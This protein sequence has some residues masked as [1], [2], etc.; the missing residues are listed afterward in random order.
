MQTR[1]ASRAA[2][3]AA[4]PAVTAGPPA[5]SK[6][7][8]RPGQRAYLE[9]V[10]HGKKKIEKKQARPLSQRAKDYLHRLY[11]TATRPGSYQGPRKILATVRKEKK[12]KISWE[13]VKAWLAGEETYTIHRQRTGS[14]KRSRVIV[15]GIGDQYDAD[16]MDISSVSEQNDGVTFTLVVIDVFSRKLW[17]E[18]M[19]NKSNEATLVALK[20]VFKRAPIPRRLRT[21]KGAEFVGKP[22]IAY[23]KSIG[24]L[25]YVTYNEQKANY[26]ERVIK[27]LKKKIFRIFTQTR[28]KRYIDVLQDLVSGYNR[29][30][31]E[32]IR[33]TPLEVTEKNETM[34]WW[35]SYLPSDTSGV[36]GLKPFTYKV[37]DVVRVSLT[38]Q[39]MDREYTERWTNELFRIRRRYYR[40]RQPVYQV[41]DYA[42]EDLDGSFY[43]VELQRVTVDADTLWRVSEVLDTR[44]SGSTKEHLV[45]WQG[46]PKK[47]NSW[48][49]ASGIK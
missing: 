6:K 36:R 39:R 14:F 32:S 48:V 35:E 4:P 34:L 20:K 23:Y 49:A 9:R 11:Y 24:V 19:T 27:T 30:Y 42:G 45:K 2:S 46:W 3:T 22:M 28:K 43:E 29:T 16:L 13:Q 7:L 21:D 37:G 33:M 5:A 1:S 44:G 47:Y 17:V 8:L 12:F 18:P 15:A 41:E 25:H 40:Q 10:L 38:R 31:H 26:C